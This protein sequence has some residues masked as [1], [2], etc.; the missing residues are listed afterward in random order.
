MCANKEMVTKDEMLTKVRA[1]IEDRGAWFALLYDEFCK[2][3]PE[4]QVIEASR[5]AIYKYGEAKVAKDPEP[6]HAKDWVI[7]HKEKGSA[8]VFDSLIEYDDEKAT[9]QMRKCPL[10]DAWNKMGYAPEK[11]DLFCDIA[12]DGDRARADGHE[13]VTMELYETIGKGCDFCRLVIRQD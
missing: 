7:R 3:L 4:E 1:A 6:F 2:L 8:D 5:K 12:M 11:V 10:V 9:Q 13:G